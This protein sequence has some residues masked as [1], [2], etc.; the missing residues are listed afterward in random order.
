MHLPLLRWFF[1]TDLKFVQKNHLKNRR[2]IQETDHA[3]FYVFGSFVERKYLNYNQHKPPVIL[4]SARY[5]LL[6]KCIE[7]LA[8]CYVHMQG[9]VIFMLTDSYHSGS[10]H[11]LVILSCSLSWPSPTSC[12]F[13]ELENSVVYPTS[14]VWLPLVPHKAQQWLIHE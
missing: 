5:N 13:S 9:K 4:L 1:S 10:L 3:D 2:C 12:L 6:V 14:Q 7:A 8:N 11:K